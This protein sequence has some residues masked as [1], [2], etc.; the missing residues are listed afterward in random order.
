[1]RA[2]LY[3]KNLSML[4]A[5]VVFGTAPITASFFSPFL[6]IMT[7]GILRI[8][9]SLAMEGLSSVFSWK[10]L[11][12]PAYSCASSLMMG[13]IILHGPHHGAQNSTSTGT[14]DSTTSVFHVLSL[15]AATAISKN[16]VKPANDAN[17]ND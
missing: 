7:V 10:K 2:P 15:T 4:V 11:N 9:Y 14:V 5:S 3:Y 16:C 6:K 17:Y 12:L 13:W 8:P 1:M